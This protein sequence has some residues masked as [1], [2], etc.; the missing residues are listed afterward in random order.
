[1]TSCTAELIVN[2]CKKSTRFA[3]WW[4]GL[5][6]CRTSWPEKH[7]TNELWSCSATWQRSQ[8]PVDKTK[9][10][11][12]ECFDD[13]LG[14]R[15]LPA[16]MPAKSQTHAAYHT[17]KTGFVHLSM[18]QMLLMLFFAARWDFAR[19]QRRHSSNG[20]WVLCYQQCTDRLSNFGIRCNC[21][22]IVVDKIRKEWVLLVLLSLT[23]VAITEWQCRYKK[24][25]KKIK[26][27]IKINVFY[28][29]IHSS[30]EGE[31]AVIPIVTSTRNNFANAESIDRFS[32][33]QFPNKKAK[34][35]P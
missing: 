31:T 8:R 30:S 28:S 26:I 32:C 13:L 16:C 12:A 9:S 15:P 10:F 5:L 11:A 21:Y 1:M 7:I 14:R 22:C 20:I 33:K 23:Y 35:V 3:C 18:L 17:T 19:I 34:V 24:K 25:K 2:H 29:W 4:A 6:L 27:K